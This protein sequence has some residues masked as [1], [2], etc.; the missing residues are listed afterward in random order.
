[1][2]TGTD[3][4]MGP[5]MALTLI[6]DA[7]PTPAATLVLTLDTIPTPDMTATPTPARVPTRDRHPEER[8]GGAAGAGD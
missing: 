3:P 4:N 5:D 6:P 7:V 1:M 8:G 2:G